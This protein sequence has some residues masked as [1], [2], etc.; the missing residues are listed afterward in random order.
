MSDEMPWCVLGHYNIW[1]RREY[2]NPQVVGVWIYENEFY[3]LF[4]PFFFFFP[5]F[6]EWDC[7]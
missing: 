7:F 5:V 3:S 4:F 2:E 1:K 6:I